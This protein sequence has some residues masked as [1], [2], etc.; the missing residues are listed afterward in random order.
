MKKLLLI[1]WLL[2]VATLCLAQGLKNDGV[3]TKEQIEST[4][5]NDIKQVISRDDRLSFAIKDLNFVADKN[6]KYM[7]DVS[8]KLFEESDL[9]TPIMTYAFAFKNLQEVKKDKTINL[10]SNYDQIFINI[11]IRKISYVL[12]EVNFTKLDNDQAKLYQEKL[13]GL[14]DFA[15]T[16]FNVGATLKSILGATDENEDEKISF[17]TKYYIPL[18]FEEHFEKIKSGIPVLVQSKDMIL[19]MVGSNKLNNNSLLGK[20]KGY[21]NAGSQIIFNQTLVP[22]T[23]FEKITGYC[24]FTFSKTFNSSLPRILDNKLKELMDASKNVNSEPEKIESLIKALD[25]KAK[26]AY[27]EDEI[28]RSTYDNIKLFTALIGIDN[29]K[30]KGSTT[31]FGVFKDE[32]VAKFSSWLDNSSGDAI[33]YNLTKIFI[34]N[35]YQNGIK[36]NKALFNDGIIFIPYSLNNDLTVYAIK[37]QQRLHEYSNSF[38]NSNPNYQNL[39]KAFTEQHEN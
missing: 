39:V 13:S 37:L 14:L 6:N 21:L 38:L 9:N 16:S 3:Y 31:T 18:N 24:T 1:M 26:E 30:K 2:S 27:D 22:E 4:L 17:S 19:T 8:V 11:D 33:N 29:L 20:I 32:V 35:T 7:I 28:S 34:R 12:I 15:F 25:E 23:D 10:K 5:K 36:N